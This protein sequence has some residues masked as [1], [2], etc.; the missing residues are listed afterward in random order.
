MI[1]TEW[2]IDDS[3]YIR[4]RLREYNIKH[5]SEKDV[6][7]VDEDFCFK[8]KDEVGNILGGVSGNTKMQ[9]LFIQFLWIDESIRG[10][11]FGKKLIRRVE[12]FAV[13][14]KCRFI[15][16]D[17]FSFQAPDFYQ[18]LGF[19]IYG[20]VEDFPEGHNHYFLIKKLS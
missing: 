10:K 18:S 15:K 16:V 11:G 2:N 1:D 8:V 5:L 13:E 20:K 3:P 19:E 14:K 7:F 9:S 12:N 17:T 4:Q 6:D